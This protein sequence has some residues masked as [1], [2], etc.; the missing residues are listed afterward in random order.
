VS[1]ELQCLPIGRDQFFNAERIAT[2]GARRT[3]MPDADS[4]AIAKAATDTLSDNRYRRRGQTVGARN[5]AH[6]G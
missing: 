3:L 4:D 2:L 6:A 1:T 5:A